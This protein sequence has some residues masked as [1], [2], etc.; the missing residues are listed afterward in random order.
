MPDI[1]NVQR[2]DTKA[3]QIDNIVPFWISY[4]AQSNYYYTGVRNMNNTH[5]PLIIIC[6]IY[7]ICKNFSGLYKHTYWW[8]RK[9][10]NCNFPY[11]CLDALWQSNLFLKRFK[12]ITWCFNINAIFYEFFLYPEPIENIFNGLKDKNTEASEDLKSQLLLI[13]CFVYLFFWSPFNGTVS[14][15]MR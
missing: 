1:S 14:C 11:T 4:C 8:V 13:I 5:K 15:Q 9:N 6:A 7:L 2:N 10:Y 12:H 3:H